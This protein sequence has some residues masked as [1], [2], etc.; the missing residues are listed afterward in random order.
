MSKFASSNSKENSTLIEARNLV[1]QRESYRL[2]CHGIFVNPNGGAGQGDYIPEADFKAN[3]IDATDHVRL[4]IMRTPSKPGD[5]FGSMPGHGDYVNVGMVLDR[6][7]KASS[8][9]AGVIAMIEEDLTESGAV[10]QP[11]EGMSRIAST[12]AVGKAIDA[13]LRKEWARPAPPP[14]VDPGPL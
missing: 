10:F 4:V 13:A 8:L 14:T 3:K 9:Q 1:K 2:A 5:D 6:L 12:P 7:G 11:G